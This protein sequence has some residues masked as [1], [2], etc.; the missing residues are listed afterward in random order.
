MYYTQNYY[1]F[2][3]ARINLNKILERNYSVKFV[4]NADTL[5]GKLFIIN[6][7]VS[8]YLLH[9]IFEALIS[10]FV[11]SNSEIL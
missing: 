3:Y 1:H 5:W 9:F 4:W 8:I 7:S 6:T 2:N 10:L 11:Y